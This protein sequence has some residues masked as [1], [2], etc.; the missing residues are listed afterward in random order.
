[1]VEVFILEG[2]EED[3]TE[4]LRWYAKR[5]LRAARGFEA[6]YAVARCDDRHQFC[7]LKRYPF[8]VIYRK[9]SDDRLL[10]VAVAHASRRPDY[11][12]NR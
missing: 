10:V 2:A 12:K 7:L 11:W 9:E 5:S 6:Q 3:Y 1:M 8:Q 4:S